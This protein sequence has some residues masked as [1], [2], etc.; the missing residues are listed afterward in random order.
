MTASI[1]NGLRTYIDAISGMT[2]PVDVSASPQNRTLPFVQVQ[3]TSR[4]DIT[5]EGDVRESFEVRSYAATP[6]A[7]QD[8]A[9]LIANDLDGITGSTIDSRTVDA[10]YID[11]LVDAVIDP[12]DGKELGGFVTVLAFRA[13][14]GV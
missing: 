12:Q 9:N 3:S 14:H 7:A 2:A 6:D 10:V 1:R 8:N 4:Q 5:F 11:G 13:D